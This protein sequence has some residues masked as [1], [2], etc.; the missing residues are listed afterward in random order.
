MKKKLT[1]VLIAVT[2]ALSFNSVAMAQVTDEDTQAV[3]A[4]AKEFYSALNVMFTGDVTTMKTLWS[5]SDDVTYMGPEG[6]ILVGWSKVM[7]E[8]ERQANLKLGGKV[9]PKDMRI[10]VGRDLAIISNFEVGEN[11]VDGKA[12]KVS[13]RATSIF[14]KEDGKWKIL[15]VVWQSPA[16][17]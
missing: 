1:G 8:W 12:Q 11:I 13:I 9:E 4:A 5:H 16:K 10:T 15:Q 7:P 2:V 14:R 17:K 6:G 3:R